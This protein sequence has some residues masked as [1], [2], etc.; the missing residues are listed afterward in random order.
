MESNKVHGGRI[1]RTARV[2]EAVPRIALPWWA[3]GDKCS[4][5]LFLCGG[6]SNNGSNA[7]P[8]Y[9]NS[10]NAFGNANSNIGARLTIKSHRRLSESPSSPNPGVAGRSQRKCRNI[11]YA[12][13]SPFVSATS[14]A[15]VGLKGLER[16]GQCNIAGLL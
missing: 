15:N 4:R 5:G 14:G 2:G 8:F 7:G 12:E 3:E 11:S 9:V 6:N 16:S 10:N 13:R 1:A